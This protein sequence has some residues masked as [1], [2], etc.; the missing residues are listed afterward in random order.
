MTSDTYEAMRERLEAEGFDRS[1]IE[2]VPHDWSQEQVRLIDPS[3][4]RIPIRDG[5]WFSLHPPS[6][7]RKLDPE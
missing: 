5:I 2:P 7:Q 3:S 6:D 4:L 1:I